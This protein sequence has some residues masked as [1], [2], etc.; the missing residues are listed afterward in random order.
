MNRSYLLFDVDQTLMASN[1]SGGA[2]MRRAFEAA[3]AEGAFDGLNYQGRT[4]LWI[5]RAVAERTGVDESTLM[6]AF[7]EDYPRAAGRG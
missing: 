4:D 3:G 2:A 6:A 1:S 5:L 7:R